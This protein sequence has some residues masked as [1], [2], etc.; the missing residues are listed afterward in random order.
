MSLLVTQV[1]I[2]HCTKIGPFVKAE[3]VLRIENCIR[4]LL[5]SELYKAF[6]RSCTGTTINPVVISLPM[7][8]AE[9]SLELLSLFLRSWETIPSLQ[10]N[11]HNIVRRD[12]TCL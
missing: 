6:D 7:M 8:R 5:Y 1:F 3:K 9:G 10:Y 4:Q 12:L 11:H 2:C